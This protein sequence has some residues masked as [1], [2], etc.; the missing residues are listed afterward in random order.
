MGFNGSG[1]VELRLTTFAL[2]AAS[3]AAAGCSAPATGGSGGAERSSALSMED[4]RANGLPHVAQVSSALNASTCTEPQQ[5]A[6]VLGQEILL[7]GLIDATNAY[8]ANPNN[9]QAMEFFGARNEEQ[10]LT[11]FYNLLWGYQTLIN[12][13][14]GIEILYSCNSSWICPAGN[15]AWSADPFVTTVC[16][17]DQAYFWQ[18]VPYVMA[19]EMWHWLGWGDPTVDGLDGDT[20]EAVRNNA[21]NHVDIAIEMPHAYY[22]Y[23]FDFIAPHAT[24]AIFEP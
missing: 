21:R 24:E 3:A 9:P 11:V 20:V 12:D 22:S 6:A 13:G 10:M 15:L 18:N 7:R 23:L 4:V 5:R 17:P 16:Q 1:F 8:S 2:L 14:Q 19:H